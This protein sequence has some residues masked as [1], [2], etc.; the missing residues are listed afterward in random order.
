MF[1]DS[2][3]HPRADISDPSS[4]QE[5]LT[6]KVQKKSLM[7]SSFRRRAVICF[8]PPTLKLLKSRPFRAV[9]DQT[10]ADKLTIFSKP[11]L[12]IIDELGYVPF[13]PEA[14]HLLFQIMSWRYETKSTIITTN[15]P[16]AEWGLVLGDP[17]AAT[18]IIDCLMHHCTAIAIKGDSYR[19]KEHKQKNCLTKNLQAA[20]EL[21]PEWHNC[22][23]QDL[24]ARGSTYLAV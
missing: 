24:S 11:K 14:P 2:I 23:G 7:I 19:L 8:P 4:T 15:R 3:R 6:G 16:I 17:M 10:A 20:K 18:A 5:K 9:Q 1:A 13:S 21:K 12:L 22:R